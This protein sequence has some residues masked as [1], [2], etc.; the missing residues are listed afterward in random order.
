MIR[1]IVMHKFYDEVSPEEKQA[2]IK[3]LRE[4]PSRMPDFEFIEWEVYEDIGR[5]KNWDTVEIAVFKD[6]AQIDTFRNH[7]AHQEVGKVFK[8]IADWHVVFYQI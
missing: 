3:M 6:E 4:L 7:P 8:G 1:H 2:A 5:E